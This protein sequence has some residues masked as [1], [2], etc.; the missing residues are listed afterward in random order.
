MWS[1]PHELLNPFQANEMGYQIITMTNDLVAK[2]AMVGRGLD[3]FSLET[4]KMFRTNAQA[5]DYTLKTSGAAGS[6]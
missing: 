5:A 1:S 3:T 2:I 4:T 6:N